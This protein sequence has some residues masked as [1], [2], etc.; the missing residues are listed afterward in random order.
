MR[1]L[2][3]AVAIALLPLSSMAADTPIDCRN[4][5]VLHLV[6]KELHKAARVIWGVEFLKR[7]DEV[8]KIM[9]EA[10]ADETKI[11]QFKRMDKR[12]EIAHDQM[13]DMQFLKP[14][15]EIEQDKLD[16]TCSAI[17][18]LDG[19]PIR[20]LYSVHFQRVLRRG[21]WSNGFAGTIEPS[22]NAQPD[23]LALYNALRTKLADIFAGR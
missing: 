10:Q 3:Y 9:T 18:E 1:L 19:T 21:E 23:T 4:P 15:K 20:V 8:K 5:E 22:V 6:S 17:F 16:N 2:V 14:T 7:L 11:P 12:L 13:Q